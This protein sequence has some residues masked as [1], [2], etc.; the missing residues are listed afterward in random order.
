MKKLKLRGMVLSLH[1]AAAVCIAIVMLGGL[2]WA[3]AGWIRSLETDHLKSECDQL[4]YALF[5]YGKSHLDVKQGSLHFD[6]D[7]RLQYSKAWTYPASQSALS[8]L[9][10]KGYLSQDVKFEDFQRKSDGSKGGSGT[11]YTVN[12]DHTK[13][14]IEVI[15]PSGKKYKTPGSR[16]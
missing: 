10:D 9:H 8:E 5:L 4:D 2:G 3:G 12:S 13:H 15:L 14:K 1:L 11:F 7:N 16:L 6:E